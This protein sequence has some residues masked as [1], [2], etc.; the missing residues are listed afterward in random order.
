[1]LKDVS[2][3]AWLSTFKFTGTVMCLLLSKINWS[4]TLKYKIENPLDIAVLTQTMIDKITH[5]D[6]Y[7]LKFNNNEIKIKAV[8]LQTFSRKHNSHQTFKI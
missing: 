8:I 5:N 4:Y 3:L 1:M 2:T 7:L 6:S